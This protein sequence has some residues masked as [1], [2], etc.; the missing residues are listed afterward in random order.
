MVCAFVVFT[1]EHSIILQPK[2][3]DQDTIPQ[4]GFLTIPQGGFLTKYYD[5][6]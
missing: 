6:G 4:G 5:N 1:Q 2:Y 3:K